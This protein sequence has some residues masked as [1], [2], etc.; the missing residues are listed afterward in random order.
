[1][2]K[3]PAHGFD[4]NSTFFFNYGDEAFDLSGKSVFTN[5][6]AISG[7]YYRQ[8]F[9]ADFSLGVF[10]V[11]SNLVF[12]PYNKEMEYWLNEITVPF[13]GMTFRDTFLL[14]RVQ[15]GTYGAGMEVALSTNLSKDITVEVTTRLGMEESQPEQMGIVDGSGYDITQTG[16]Y[17][18]SQFQYVSTTINIGTM[19]LGCLEYEN[20]T[21][22]SEEK[23]FEYSLFE[24][25]LEEKNMP[26]SLEA[27]LRFTPQTK[28]LKLDPEIN[29]GWACFEVYSDI[30]HT[31]EKLEG[32]EIEGL[33]VTDVQ[34]GPATLSSMTALKDILYKGLDES[35]I[36][37]R[38]Q[39]YLVDPDHP[40]YYSD[41]EYDEV[42]SLE[43]KPENG[44]TNSLYLGTDLY[45]KMSQSSQIFDLSKLT[46]EARYGMTEYLELDTGLSYNLE[47]MDNSTFMMGFNLVF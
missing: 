46:A 42:F 17:G 16:S 6:K 39:D 21:V 7:D 5:T 44:I 43:I 41:T 11:G 26:L 33:G 2:A 29:L 24:F 3:T 45:F 23:G 8:T 30:T 25:L 35:D 1:M 32:L 27:D 14:E 28:S 9:D 10:D 22:F 12:H 38:A 47:N 34:L 18:P 13:A 4:Y 15:T 40:A 36:H 31:G 37:L 20:E 19:T